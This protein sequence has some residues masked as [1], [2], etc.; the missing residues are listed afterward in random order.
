MMIKDTL[1]IVFIYLDIDE[2]YKI[3]D[4]FNL[5]V[6]FFCK[7]TKD[8]CKRSSSWNDY[9]IYNRSICSKMDWASGLSYLDVVKFLHKNGDKCTRDAMYYASLNNHS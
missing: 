2:Y 8:I 9:L 6:Q 1:S 3:K 4:D 5:S 7:N